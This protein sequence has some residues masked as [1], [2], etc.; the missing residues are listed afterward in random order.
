MLARVQPID[1]SLP[2]LRAIRRRSEE[3]YVGLKETFAFCRIESGRSEFWMHGRV[4]QARP[5]SVVI[6]QPGD[7][8]RDVSRR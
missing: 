7:V 1:V 2:G 6:Q 5:G 3:P 8:H 4:W